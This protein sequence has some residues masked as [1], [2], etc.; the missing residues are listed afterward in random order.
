MA[1]LGPV[2]EG[3]DV[4]AGLL[5]IGEFSAACRLSPKALRLYDRLGLLRPAQVDAVSGYRWY[6]PGADRS[7]PARWACCAGWRCRWR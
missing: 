1:G 4:G 7:G 5:S 6:G 2:K 3:A